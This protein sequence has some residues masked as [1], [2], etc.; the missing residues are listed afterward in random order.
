MLLVKLFCLLLAASCCH[1][2]PSANSSLQN[3]FKLSDDVGP[4]NAVFAHAKPE[5]E[6]YPGIDGHLH[7]LRNIKRYNSR[8]LVRR[9]TRTSCCAYESGTFEL[10][11]GINR[12]GTLLNIYKTNNFVQE[13]YHRSCTQQSLNQP[14]KFV[15]NTSKSRC[16]QRY[17]YQYALVTQV[18]GGQL[19]YDYIK[20]KSGC[21]CEV[22]P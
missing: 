15:Q 11:G 5:A 13:F 19:Q 16:T 18:I 14:C 6:I 10:K 3:V 7:H 21:E 12:Q 22:A 20:V 17:T 4:L 8:Y 9:E 2:T 1:S